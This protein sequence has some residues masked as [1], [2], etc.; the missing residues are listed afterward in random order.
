MPHKEAAAQRRRSQGRRGRQRAA[1]GGRTARSPRST[2]T[3]RLP[4]CARRSARPIGAR[5]VQARACSRRGRRGARRSAEALRR[6]VDAIVTSPTARAARAEQPA[7]GLPNGRAVR[8]DDLDARLRRRR[9]DRAGDDA[10]HGGPAGSA[11]GRS[12]SAGAGAIVADIVY[13]PLETALLRAARERGLADRGR[14][15]HADP[16]RRAFV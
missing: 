3:A 10:G 16:P 13:R 6:Y 4:R 5:S 9:S 1:L 8:W 7:A 15:G 2:R 14:A 11:I 12:M